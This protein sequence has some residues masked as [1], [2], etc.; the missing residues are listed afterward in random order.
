MPWSW[1]PTRGSRSKRA[2]EC[3]CDASLLVALVVADKRQDSARAHLRG[4]LDAGEGLHGPAVLPYEVA[5]VLARL[6]FDGALELAEVDAIWA[7]LSALGLVL[8]PFDLNR[9][10][11]EVAA[12]TSLLRRRPA[13]GLHLPRAT[14][15]DSSVDSGQ[16]VG[17]QRG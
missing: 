17:P 4:W 15:R 2:G 16:A 3:C 14:A 6:T 8:H 12:M 13:S 1:A 11:R 9:D 10:G 7:D 5:N